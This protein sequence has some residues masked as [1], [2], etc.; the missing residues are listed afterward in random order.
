MPDFDNSFLAEDD[1]PAV[2][3]DALVFEVA[4]QKLGWRA[5]GLALKRASDHGTEVGEILTDLQMIF[6]SDLSQE[7]LEE[8]SEE[9]I[10]AALDA[11]AG[12]SDF[13]AMI[14]K[15][16]WVGVL[17]FEPNARQ[18]NVLALI[19]TESLEDVPFE[20]MLS[21][22][23][24]ALEEAAEDSGEEVEEEGKGSPQEES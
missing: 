18:E 11:Q 13:I 16:V 15:A 10:E 12:I 17:H 23:F 9:E 4:G 22:I 3:E 14:A 20:Q 6:T 19:D 2:H 7:D 8:M 1:H 24:P 21:K 5:S